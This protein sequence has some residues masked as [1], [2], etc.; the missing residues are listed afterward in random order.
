MLLDKKYDIY[1]WYDCNRL[2]YLGTVDLRHQ[3][4]Q[5]KTT[6]GNWSF[7][8]HCVHLDSWICRILYYFCSIC[9][10]RESQA[11]SHSLHRIGIDTVRRQEKMSSLGTGNI[12]HPSFWCNVQHV[13]MGWVRVDHCHRNMTHQA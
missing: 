8:S 5:L 9:M 2:R 4:F 13:M 6:T 12:L 10:W 7:G 3:S 11:P 1:I